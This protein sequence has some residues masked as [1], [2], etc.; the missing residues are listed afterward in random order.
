MEL[1]KKEM[2]REVEIFLVMLALASKLIPLIFSILYLL[3][4][5]SG[6]RPGLRLQMDLIKIFIENTMN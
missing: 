6:E 1:S 2:K 5:N 4:L 3:H